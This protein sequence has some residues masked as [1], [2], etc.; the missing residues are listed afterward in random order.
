M[1]VST[2]QRRDSRADKIA[3]KLAQVG[4]LLLFLYPFLPIIYN[5]V[6]FK[7]VPILSS[8]LLPWDP[9]L[10]FGQVLNRDWSNLVI[11]APLL[12]LAG[13]WVFGRFFCGWV[14][15]LGTVLDLIRPLA[16]WQRRQGWA[17]DTVKWFPLHSNSPF[18]YYLLVGVLASSVF[19]LKALGL[20]DPLVVFER[21]LAAILSDTFVLRLQTFRISFAVPLLFLSILALEFWQPRFWC[22]HLCPSGALLSLFARG[23]VIHRRVSEGCNNCGDCRRHCAM[24]AIPK[25]LVKVCHG[26][27]SVCTGCEWGAALLKARIGQPYYVDCRLC[28]EC[29]G[30]CPQKAIS[31]GLATPSATSHQ[32]SAFRFRLS[33]FSH[34]LLARLPHAERSEASPSE[35][36]HASAQ[37]PSGPAQKDKGRGAGTIHEL[38]LLSRREFISGVAVGVIGL[39]F[40]STLRPTNQRAVIRPPGALPEEEFIHTCITCQECVRVCPTGGLKP[41]LLAAGLSGVGTP[42]LVPLHGACSLNPSCPHLCAK[43]CPAAAIKPIEPAA[44][45]IGLAKVNRSLCLAWDQGTKCLVC[46]EA[47]VTG[48]AR[49]H[50]GRIVVDPTRCIGCGRCE[51]ACPIP[52]SAIRVSPL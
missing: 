50:N 28:L 14:C 6:T 38:P 20:L 27:C 11:G 4:F 13:T 19:S 12:L 3:R 10:F 7:P 36:P 39:I 1:T 29:E 49:V 37:D 43:V 22:R 34:Q 9:L 21:T 26:N 30:I 8:W 16:I 47:C 31:F 25:E 15:P 44:M 40:P 17:K 51:Y 41:T 52:G 45:K 18:R 24:R 33:A 42:H 23:S 2:S 35:A 5:R 46:V 48:A 32:P